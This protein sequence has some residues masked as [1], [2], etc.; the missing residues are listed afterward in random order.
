MVFFTRR[1]L[2]VTGTSIGNIDVGTEIILN[3][4][5]APINYL[6][7]NQGIPENSALYDSSC[8]GTWLLRKDLRENRQWNASNVNDYA[9][10]TIHS[11]LNS[12]FL[13]LFDADIREVIKQVKIPYVNGT[14]NSAVASGSSGLSC[15]IFLLSGR[16]VG[17][18]ASDNPYFPNDGAKL[19][20]FESGTGSSALNKRIAKLNGSA[21]VWWLRSPDTYDTT[22]AWR[23]ISS[24]NY[25][26]VSCTYSHGIRPA[27]VLPFNFKLDDSQIIS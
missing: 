12:T 16:E 6:I 23:V 26:G 27:L 13:N 19:S 10:S 20:Y 2:P 22:N 11:Y 8:D 14:G 17:F 9:N 25:S 7:V 5:G 15:K 4:N 18:S 21:T 3:E 1:F 24:G